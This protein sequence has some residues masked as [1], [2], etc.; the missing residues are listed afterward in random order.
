MSGWEPL[1]LAAVF[2]S[3]KDSRHVRLA[4]CFAGINYKETSKDEK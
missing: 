2:I 1:F 3:Q 4:R